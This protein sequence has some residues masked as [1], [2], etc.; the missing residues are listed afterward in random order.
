MDVNVQ[1]SS[2]NTPLHVAAATGNVSAFKKLVQHTADVNILN[3]SGV[4]P[5]SMAIGPYNKEDDIIKILISSKTKLKTNA[6]S[7]K[8]YAIQKS[9]ECGYNKLL[10]ELLSCGFRVHD[11]AGKS[12]LV[13][14]VKNGNVGATKQLI[15]VGGGNVNSKVDMPGDQHNGYSLLMMAVENLDSGM[16]KM[17]LAH[18]CDV[19]MCGPNGDTACHML[20]KSKKVNFAR[21]VINE[22]VKSGINLGE[23]FSQKDSGGYTPLHLAVESSNFAV[24]SAAVKAM[25]KRSLLGV[26]GLTSPGGKTLLHLC[27]ETGKLDLVKLVLD[28]IGAAEFGRLVT[29]QDGDGNTILHKALESGDDKMVKLVMGYVSKGAARTLSNTR[30][31][32]GNTP[33]HLALSSES[34]YAEKFMYLCNMDVFLSTNSEGKSPLGCIAPGSKFFKP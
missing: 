2:G 3:T 8:N 19:A 9:V 7:D 24:A 18:K 17:L 23:A 13:S 30:N 11:G 33:L 10:G 16:T 22:M 27:V 5:V 25:S 20:V 29:K 12:P 31:K 1:N 26:A 32:L 21:Y 34:F 4:S 6:D 28:R 14:A 15:E